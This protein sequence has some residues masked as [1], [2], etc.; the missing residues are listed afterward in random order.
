[1]K[2]VCLVSPKADQLKL[3]LGIRF[4]LNSL[5]TFRLVFLL[6]LSWVFLLIG[7]LGSSHDRL[8]VASHHKKMAPPLS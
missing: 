6:S 4:V 5:L 7:L 1:M 2:N 3:V 8:R